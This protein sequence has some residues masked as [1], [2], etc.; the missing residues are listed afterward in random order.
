LI[1]PVLL[2]DPVRFNEPDRV[3]IYKNF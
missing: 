1:D 2:K 3:G